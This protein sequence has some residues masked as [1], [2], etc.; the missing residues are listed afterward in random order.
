M[1]YKALQ[2]III[3]YYHIHLFLSKPKCASCVLS[4]S[5]CLLFSLFIA[6][7]T[8]SYCS[9]KSIL[10]AKQTNLWKSKL[11][12]CLTKSY[13]SSFNFMHSVRTRNQKFGMKYIAQ[14][15]G[16]IFIFAIMCSII[17]QVHN[18]YV[19]EIFEVVLLQAPLQKIC[20]LWAFT[21]LPLSCT[22]HM[23]IK[24]HIYICMHLS[25]MY[26]CTYVQVQVTYYTYCLC[27]K[28][29]PM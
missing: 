26:P 5:H 16:R 4:K 10:C 2:I 15:L 8:S 22:V 23:S 7:F 20:H 25:N 27:C 11:F 9:F 17:A 6:L 18:N 13:G 21:T 1:C 14:P 29:I 24:V 3:S 19:L 12:L 28:C